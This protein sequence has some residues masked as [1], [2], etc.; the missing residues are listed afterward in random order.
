MKKR[1]VLTLLTSL[2]CFTSVKSFAEQ[3]PYGIVSFPSCVTE[4]K[5]G[6]KEQEGFDKLREQMAALVTDTEKKLNDL[7]T[8]YND[9]EFM[10][11]LSPEAE[12]EMH[13]QAQTLSEERNRYQNQF[14]QVMQ[15]A[16]MQLMQT[17]NGHVQKA[18]EIIAKK[19]KL[20]MVVREDVCF[21]YNPSFDITKSIISEMDK[22]FDLENKDQAVDAQ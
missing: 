14:M 11:S 1:C 20:P 12:Q 5:Y 17:M 3:I 22:S 19:K 2:L 4:S 6:K 21:F 13:A 15:Q 18:S 8:K 9:P 10:D 7:A 16:N